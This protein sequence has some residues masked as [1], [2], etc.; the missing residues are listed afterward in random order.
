MR[1]KDGTSFNGRR[2]RVNQK[3]EFLVDMQKFVEERLK[4][5]PIAKGRKAEDSAT[6]EEKDLTRA[7]VGSITWAA[8]EG[9]PDAA[10][11]ASLVAS[12]LTR[13]TRSDLCLRVQPIR[14]ERLGWG[15]ITDASFANASHKVRMQ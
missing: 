9:R 4:K 10:A 1:I 5:V 11:I 15:V 3:Q 12:N 8:K 2:I 14:P 13:L 6:Q 7:A